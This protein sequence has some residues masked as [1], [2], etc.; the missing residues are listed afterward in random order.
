MSIDEATALI[1]E[2]G[3]SRYPVFE[4]SIDHIVGVVLARDVWRA[5]T[6]N[7]TDIRAAM[8]PALFVPDTKPVEALLREMRRERAHLAVVIDEFGGTAGI[9][10]IEDVME[11]IVGEIEDELD[12]VPAEVVTGPGG[13]LLMSGGFAIAELNELYGLKLPDTDY[14]TV[15]GFMLGRLG[16]VA[17]VGDEITIRGGRLRVLEMDS[18]RVA[19][20]ALFLQPGTAPGDTAEVDED[21]E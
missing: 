4:D 2:E 12:D 21:W 14:T 5:Q 15:G 13:E 11:E 7:V 16:R 10:T 9:V 20:L 6:E 19:R 18:R 8:R 1:L 17:R 3:H